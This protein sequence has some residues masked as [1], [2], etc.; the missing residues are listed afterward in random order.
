V[1]VLGGGLLRCG[2]CWAEERSSALHVVMSK[3]QLD[4]A[5]YACYGRTQ[6]HNCSQSAVPDRILLR[7]I[8]T[9]LD[10]LVLAE[11]NHMRQF[12]PPSS[13]Q[14]GSEQQGASDHDLA[15]QRTRIEARLERQQQLYEFGDWSHD[16]FTPSVVLDGVVY[17]ASFDGY[18]RSILYA[19]NASNGTEYWHGDYPQHIVPI[20]VAG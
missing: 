4:R 7:Q 15:V 16:H 5:S 17:L 3:K 9:L 10:E 18:K 14:Q 6:G 2:Y 8:S 13:E 12:A 20:A 19:L 1:H 11:G